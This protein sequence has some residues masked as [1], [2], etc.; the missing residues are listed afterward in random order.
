[1]DWDKYSTSKS[2]LKVAFN[3]SIIKSIPPMFQCPEMAVCSAGGIQSRGNL[4]GYVNNASRGEIN[5]VPC[6][7]FHC[8]QSSTDCQSY[9][10]CRN[11][12]T[13]ALCGK[14]HD[15]FSMSLFNE[16][17]CVAT[18]QCE[19]H[20]IWLLILVSGAFIVAMYTYPEKIFKLFDFL[21]RKKKKRNKLKVKEMKIPS[22]ENSQEKSDNY[23]NLNQN[24]SDEYE[25]PKNHEQDDVDKTL[26]QSYPDE[27]AYLT[28]EKPKED[29]V[30]ERLI[31]NCPDEFNYLTNEKPKE[32]H[33]SLEM[34]K[35]L[36]FFYQTVGLL[37]LN[38]SVT[39]RS[40]IL[41]EI[42]SSLSS[43]KLQIP[44]MKYNTC[45]LVTYNVFMMEI[46]KL[47]SLFVSLAIIISILVLSLIHI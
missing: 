12:R 27:L 42:L 5:F 22:D 26:N 8:C 21:E 4:W 15:G 11:E 2:T 16:Y 32:S 17:G 28:N 35:L 3:K 40:L 34:M 29:D 10:T 37:L 14:C 36:M 6:P 20:L 31:Q 39:S 41:T 45:P 38:N 44:S 25:T 19:N 30:N 24:Y 33:S 46:K 43:I 1:M 7:A 13:G 47:S 9:D 23:Q 18:D